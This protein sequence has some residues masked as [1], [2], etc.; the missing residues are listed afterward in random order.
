MR[1]PGHALIENRQFLVGCNIRAS[2]C[3]LTDYFHRSG[4]YAIS[5]RSYALPRYE[6]GEV[7][8][9]DPSVT[10]EYKV[11]HA[12]TAA[13]GRDT[14]RSASPTGPSKAL[15]HNGSG[16][17]HV[18]AVVTST[19]RQQHGPGRPPVNLEPQG[20]RQDEQQ[21]EPQEAPPVNVHRQG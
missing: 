12:P 5:C 6:L 8:D 11:L 1:H 20:E 10:A 7:R 21:D 3:G 15:T 18:P 19:W 9:G 16:H 2:R 14:W 17:V 4:G 13:S